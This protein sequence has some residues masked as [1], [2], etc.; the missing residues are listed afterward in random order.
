VVETGYYI[1]VPCSAIH[2][3]VR[4]DLISVELGSGDEIFQYDPLICME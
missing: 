3:R 2:L 1:G 4:N